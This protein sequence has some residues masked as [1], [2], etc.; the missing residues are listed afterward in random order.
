MTSSVSLRIT[1]DT[2]LEEVRYFLKELKKCKDF[3]IKDL[4]NNTL[5]KKELKQ[6]N[7]KPKKES[8]LM[9]IW[10]SIFGE[11]VVEKETWDEVGRGMEKKVLSYLIPIDPED[12]FAGTDLLV[13]KDEYPGT[14]PLNGIRYTEFIK[15]TKLL[16]K[17]F[18]GVTRF[19][20]DPMLSNSSM[21]MLMRDFIILMTRKTSRELIKS[22]AFS[23]YDT[24]F[25]EGE[26]FETQ[27]LSSKL[28]NKLIRQEVFICSKKFI[29]SHL[30][31]AAQLG[32]KKYKI[33]NPSFM[34]LAHELIHVKNNQQD[35][36]H[37]N[38]LSELKD[39]EGYTHREERRAISGWEKK[40][41]FILEDGKKVEEEDW[42]A[43]TQDKYSPVNEWSIRA[44]FGLPVRED[45]Y[46]GGNFSPGRIFKE[47]AKSMYLECM[48]FDAE[49]DMEKIKRAL[50]P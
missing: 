44:E 46:S 18:S 12:R 37:T 38:A 26:E 27:S 4:C 43:I 8:F 42:S 7:I 41:D 15:I 9:K 6:A 16:P 17:I 39:P 32:R 20:F 25:R 49:I 40:D 13:F 31:R 21:R 48:K 33:P 14:L 29:P 11:N 19:K 23:S 30:G 10:N 5:F 1:Q 50:H 35:L 34:S 36:H 22:L 47:N 24:T 28:S 2:L 3:S 45:H